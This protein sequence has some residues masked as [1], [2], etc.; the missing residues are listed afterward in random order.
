LGTAQKNRAHLQRDKAAVR[1][2]QHGLSILRSIEAKRNACIKKYG[3]KWDRETKSEKKMRSKEYAAFFEAYESIDVRQ[4][5]DDELK[6]YAAMCN[7]ALIE[8]QNELYKR[9]L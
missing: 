7:N 1:P 8:A 5:A 6:D 2:R 9:G 3:S 4:L